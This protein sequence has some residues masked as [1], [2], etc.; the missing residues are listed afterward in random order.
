MRMLEIDAVSKSFR[1]GVRARKVMAVSDLSFS[2]DEGSEL[3]GFVGPNGAGKT[4][5]IKMILGLVRPTHGAIRVFGTNAGDPSCRSRIAFVS[6]QPYFYPHLSVFESL[7]FAGRL[8][9]VSRDSLNER[10]EHVLGAIGLS[11]AAGNKVR[12]LSKGMQQRLNMGQALLGDADFFV[13]DEPMSGMDPPG[14]SLFRDIFRD[15]KAKGKSVFFST[16]ILEDIETLCSR[17][18]VL[19]HGRLSYDG[20][21]EELLAT[22][23]EGTDMVAPHL[24]GSIREELSSYGC[25]VALTPAGAVQ[26]FVPAHLDAKRV[27]AQLVAHGVPF[28]SISQRR[29]SLETLLYDRRG[30]TDA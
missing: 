3:T 21:V 15:L 24:E 14:R 22:G 27:Q 4:T 18:I 20:S 28:D 8:R 26:I 6:E 16:H 30:G 5:T 9:G 7:R 12:E 25:S 10:I 11:G 13:F 29:K 23:F 1:V 17:V 19:S 2:V